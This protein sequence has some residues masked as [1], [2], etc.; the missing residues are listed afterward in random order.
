MKKRLNHKWRC[1]FETLTLKHFISEVLRF[2]LSYTCNKYAI[3]L[4]LWLYNMN[5]YWCRIVGNSLQIDQQDVEIWVYVI[6]LMFKIHFCR[7]ECARPVI[8]SSLMCS[9]DQV[10]LWNSA[11]IHL[12]PFVLLLITYYECSNSVL[13]S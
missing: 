4:M 3:T 7:F 12:C 6:L 11:F 13:L 2:W 1:W 10:L 5:I 8:L 9:E